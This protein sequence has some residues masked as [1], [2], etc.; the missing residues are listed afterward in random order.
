MEWNEITIETNTIGSELVA[1]II[2]QNGSDVSI[3]DG[4][5]FNDLIQNKEV[6]VSWDYYDDRLKNF[7]DIVLCKGYF[8]NE[9]IKDALH[10]IQNDLINLKDNAEFDIGT[11]KLEVKKINDADW[12]NEWKKYYKQIDVGKYAIVPVW[13]KFN[14][15]GQ[16]SIV[17]NPGMAFGTGEHESTQLCLAL[18]SEVEVNKKNIIDMGTGSGILGIAAAK[19]GA[20]KVD[21]YDIDPAAIQNAKE[22]VKLNQVE[23]SV[24][25]QVKPI[26][27]GYNE[28]VDIIIANITADILISMKDDFK[29]SLVDGGIIIMSGIINSRY[30]DVLREFSNSGF[31]FDKRVV[32]REWSGIR[33]IKDGN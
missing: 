6:G 28:G 18:L 16:I 12:N 24:N 32:A 8:S 3:F 13:E 2:S 25:L 22:N 17:I 9:D 15:K 10:E 1:D 4:N 23:K 21:M 30:N 31:K 5:D 29:T 11:L 20:N 14:D 19:S 7:N 26:I 27:D 33:F